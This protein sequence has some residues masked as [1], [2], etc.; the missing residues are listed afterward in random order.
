MNPTRGLQLLRRLP[1]RTAREERGFSLLE[2][3]VVILIIG[4]LAA[5]A[6]PLFINHAK[7]ADD[8][9]AKSLAKDLATEVE[10][11]YATDEDFTQCDTPA[12][13][14]DARGPVGK[15]PRRNPRRGHHEDDLRGRRR[16]EG[17]DRRLEPHLHDQA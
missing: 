9:D 12:K 15:Q 2:L 3:L 6:I 8:T 10:L 5:I 17:A 11:C 1:Q 7:N 13:L 14:G 16:L 4:I